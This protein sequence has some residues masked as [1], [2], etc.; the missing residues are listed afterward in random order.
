VR[1]KQGYVC[2]SVCAPSRA[3]MLTGRADIGFEGNA[4]AVHGLNL[5][6]ETM[7]DTMR[8]A[9]YATSCI[10]KWHL[11]AQDSH[12]PTERGF[13]YFCGLREGSRSYFYDESNSDSPGNPHGIE[14]NGEQIKFEGYLT[15]YLTDQAIGVIDSQVSATPDKPF[16]MFLSYTAPHGPMHCKPGTEVQGLKGDKRP[17]YAAMVVS[18]DKGV[19]RVL[20]TLEEKGLREN[21]LVVFLSDNGG[22]TY[23]NGSSNWPLKGKKGSTD[24]GGLRVPFMIQWPGK[25]PSAQVRDEMIISLDL[26]PTFAAVAGVKP[27]EKMSG[28][29]LMPYLADPQNRL[30]DR[31]FFWRRGGM[32]QCAYRSGDYK[33]IENRNKGEQYLYNLRDD[34][35]EKNNVVGQFPEVVK[36]MRTQYAKW[37]SNIPDPPPSAGTKGKK[38]ERY[39]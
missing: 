28:L 29:N 31:G 8:R 16:F 23:K 7:A 26:L 37:E 1:F 34:I 9:G 6:L 2:N 25:I 14:I 11:G 27:P 36:K 13:D 21:T 3:G 22:P 10:G 24:E 15:D 19:G 32:K 18:L 35:R 4:D 39:K 30:A 33:W 5:S 17:V 20:Q 12:Y 38:K